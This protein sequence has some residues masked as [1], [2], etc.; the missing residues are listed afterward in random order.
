[1]SFELPK[2]SFLM[3]AL[4]PNISKE[5]LEYHYGKHHQGYINKLNKLV[6]GTGYERMT[7]EEIVQKADG[8]IFN[9]AAQ[10]WNH[11]FYWKSISP[12]IGQIP[13]EKLLNAIEAKFDSMEGFKAQFKETALANFGSGWTWLVKNQQGDLEI[14]NT[15]NAGNPMT[16]G[17][18]PLLT[19]D[20]W[21]HAYY[22]DVRNDRAQYLDN[23][24]ELLEW[25]TAEEAF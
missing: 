11:A 2:L 22:I 10:A 20:V 8:A 18:T 7:L 5:T 14:V 12:G 3:D 17:K 25:S 6:E 1:M 24:L 19:C 13:G 4:E 23:F 21:E 9:N 15:S 16:E